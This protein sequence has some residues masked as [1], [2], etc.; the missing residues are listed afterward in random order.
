MKLVNGRP[1]FITVEGIDGVGKSTA[2]DTMAKY[3]ESM[4][5]NTVVVRQNKDTYLA[6]EIRKFISCDEAL[7]TSPTTFAFLFCASI[8]DSIEKL[9]E[10]AHLN[11]KIVISDRYTM[12]TRVYQHESKYIDKVCG[13]I[14]NQ[15]TPD[16]TFVLDAPPSVVKARIL[17]RN[18]A[19]DVI[20]SVDDD[21]LNIRRKGFVRH[22]RRSGK[23]T[24]IIDASGT[25]EWVAEQIIDILDTYFD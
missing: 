24:Y 23:N 14:E 9:I 15:L 19:T 13:I 4:G 17:N 20:E 16:V 25:Q 18:E 22:A 2:V 8:N 11:G 10:P 7:T 3:I 5:L 6:K 12:S 1:N 21:I